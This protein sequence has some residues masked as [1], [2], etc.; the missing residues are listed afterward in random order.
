MPTYEYECK[1]CGK[2][3][4]VFH[5]MSEDGPKRCKEPK[6]RGTLKRLIGAGAGLI[7]KG[8]G[9]YIT[10]YKNKESGYKKDKSKADGEGSSDSKSKDKSTDKSTDKSKNKSN[11]K[12][13]TPSKSSSE[14]KSKKSNDKN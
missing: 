4:D 8:S 12:S 7:F 5:G 9:F 14:S 1:K 11:D 13:A 10:D 6:C 3:I 2:V